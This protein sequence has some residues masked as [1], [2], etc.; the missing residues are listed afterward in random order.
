MALFSLKQETLETFAAN[1]TQQA[2]MIHERVEQKKNKAIESVPLLKRIKQE[3]ASF[4]QA[5]TKK[6]G[7][8]YTKV[9]NIAVGVGKF[10][11]AGQFGGP[12]IIALGTINAAKA[13][14]PLLKNAEKARVEGKV[15]GLFDY[16]SKNRKEALHTMTNASLGAGAIA[17]GL[18]GM[19]DA[20]F[21]TRAAATAL[22]VV[23]EMKALK[24]TVKDIASGKKTTKQAFKDLGRDIVTVGISAAS[25]IAGNYGFLTQENNGSDTTHSAS[26]SNAHSHASANN[27]TSGLSIGV[28]GAD[29]IEAKKPSKNASDKNATTP[30]KTPSDKRN[31][32]QTLNKMS[33]ENSQETAPSALHKLILKKN[34]KG[35]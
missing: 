13:I 20:K 30:Q 32:Q 29:K 23:P 8:N 11:V 9:R 5:M 33:Q 6:L 18:A 10:Y 31:L 19:L 27:Q 28:K 25:F 26:G 3:I 21:V 14:K 15:S 24:E 4:D 1:A 2:M 22:V 16:M 12:G 34:Q 35:I 7:K 17:F